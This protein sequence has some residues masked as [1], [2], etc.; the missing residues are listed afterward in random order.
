MAK[1]AD[2][3]ISA[4]KYNEERTHIERVRVHEDNGVNVGAPVNSSRLTGVSNIKSGYSYVT[5]YKTTENKWKKGEDVRI[6]KV[7]NEEFIRTDAN[8]TAA[9]NLGDLPEYC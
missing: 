8:Q 1:W 4:V 6:I 2:F 5:I 3:L 7:G 9:D